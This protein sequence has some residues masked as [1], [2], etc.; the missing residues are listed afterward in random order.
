MNKLSL[1][2]DERLNETV[3]TVLIDN[4]SIDMREGA[5]YFDLEHTTSH[6]KTKLL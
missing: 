6:R 4:T 3:D 1:I 2:L 5:L